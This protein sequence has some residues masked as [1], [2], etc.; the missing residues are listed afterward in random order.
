[1]QLQTEIGKGFDSSI[2]LLCLEKSNFVW[3][4][5]KLLNQFSK[6]KLL[7]KFI[8]NVAYLMIK[9][10]ISSIKVGL[11]LGV[12]SQISVPV[13][14]EFYWCERLA[15]SFYKAAQCLRYSSGNLPFQPFVYSAIFFIFRPVQGTTWK[16]WSIRNRLF[17]DFSLVLK[18]II[19]VPA[20]YQ[21]SGWIFSC[22]NQTLNNCLGLLQEDK[23]RKSY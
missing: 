19:P 16:G 7:L 10:N 5:K 21:L 23:L 3:N 12:V 9:L 22:I 1:M 13:C 11:P 2:M 15:W 6:N 20:T 18:C 14:C 17:Q 8:Y 4:N